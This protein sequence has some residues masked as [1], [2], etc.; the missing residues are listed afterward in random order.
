MTCTVGLNSL[1]TLGK[2]LKYD[3]FDTQHVISLEMS[4]FFFTFFFFS[5]PSPTSERPS[6]LQHLWA[7]CDVQRCPQTVLAPADYP[8]LGWRAATLARTHGLKH[9]ISHFL[10]PAE[11]LS[12]FRADTTPPT[13]SL[14]SP[15]ICPVLSLL[16]LMSCLLAPVLHQRDSAPPPPPVPSCLIC[17][18]CFPCHPHQALHLR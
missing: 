5:T 11:Y 3:S 18:S 16:F 7:Q 6:C 9:L 10:H 4:G 1:I 15:L 13:L 12:P 14:L 17:T 8:P 2:E